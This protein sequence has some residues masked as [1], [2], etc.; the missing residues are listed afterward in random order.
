MFFLR[1]LN[2][3][4]ILFRTIYLKIIYYWNAFSLLLQC[5]QFTLDKKTENTE[6]KIKKT[7]VSLSGKER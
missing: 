5:F 7:R 3:K 6:I 2:E 4:H 1:S